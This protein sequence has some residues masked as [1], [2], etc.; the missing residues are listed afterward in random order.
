VLKED[1]AALKAELERFSTRV[2]ELFKKVNESELANAVYNFK[3]EELQREVVQL[4]EK[5]ST[6]KVDPE[7]EYKLAS[8]EKKN[9]DLEKKN[10]ELEAKVK[11]LIR[12]NADLID[13]LKQ[14]ESYVK[15]EEVDHIK[16]EGEIKLKNLTKEFTSSSQN[17]IDRLKIENELKLKELKNE[18]SILQSTV[19]K[20]ISEKGTLELELLNVNRKNVSVSAQSSKITFPVKMDQKSNIFGAILKKG[21]ETNKFLKEAQKESKE[22]EEKLNIIMKDKIEDLKKLRENIIRMSPKTISTRS[23][24][25]NDY[26]NIDFDNEEEFKKMQEKLLQ[27]EKKHQEEK[28]R[29]EKLKDEILKEKK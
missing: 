3:I 25:D 29:L 16:E 2:E 28:Q 4:N 15:K 9:G 11:E 20:L 8:F 21:P 26:Q 7:L 6:Q 14:K 24:P 27:R 5:L 17:T 22:T 19:N 1:N 23:I 13:Q 10:D 12:Q 18:I